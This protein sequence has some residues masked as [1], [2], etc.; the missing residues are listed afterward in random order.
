M[1]LINAMLSL[2]ALA[3][4]IPLAIHLLFR[5]RFRSIQWGAMHLLD[6]VV[7][8][9]HRRLQWLQILLLLLRC[10]L[11]VLLA[12][13]LARPVLTGFRSLPGDAPQSLI[14]AVD[15]SRSMSARDAAGQ[16]S[17][18]RARQMLLR[19]VN[20]LS[21]QD[22]V[23][24]IRS[25]QLGQPAIVAGRTDA[26]RR[27][28]DLSADTG[29]IDLPG[30]VRASL[31]AADEA[32]HSQRR[33]VI[34]SDFQDIDLSDDTIESLQR[35]DD[36]IGDGSDSPSISFL[37]VGSTSPS[38]GNVYFESV[39]LD[40]PA[41]IAGRETRLT[42]QIQNASDVPKQSV[43]VTWSVDSEPFASS[44][45]AMDA[46]SSTTI[47][48]DLAIDQT[49]VH[50]L[51][52]SIE[53]ADAIS[54]DNQRSLGVDV[55]HEV[56]VV[57]VDGAPS[58][59]PMRAETDF[60]IVALSPLSLANVDRTDA[61]RS[62]VIG[63]QKIAATIRDST[64]DVLVLANV[65]EIG[66][67]DRQAVADFVINGGSLV[68]FDGDLV[69]PS[70]Y[71]ERWIGKQGSWLLPATLGQVVGSTTDQNAVSIPIDPA[72]HQ[73]AP[74]R[75]LNSQDR[76]MFDDVELFGYRSLTI[77][78]T[79][80]ATASNSPVVMLSTVGRDPL[81]LS[82]VRGRGQIVQFAIPCDDAWSG[83]PLRPMFVPMIQQLVLDLAGSQKEA[84][85]EIGR[86]ISI[87]ISE[88]HADVD[89]TTKIE[90]AVVFP[91]EKRE[92]VQ[93]DPSSVPPAL[94]VTPTQPGLHR[95][96][97][98]LRPATGPTVVSETS[99]IVEVPVAESI[100]RDADTNRLNAA[101]API[102]AKIFFDESDL[103]ADDHNRRYGR[104]VWRPLLALVLAAMIGEVVL[105]QF[106]AGID[107]LGNRASVPV[108]RQV[109][110]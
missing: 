13:C 82:A 89:D 78:P 6:S 66:Q 37:S 77:N 95:L 81:I 41:V 62:T 2:G 42:A 28:R 107:V 39:A 18:Q 30:V 22:E 35:L 57:L 4:T 23:I 72:N 87:P 52:V 47:H 17:M 50:Q 94:I 44:E 93:T 56:S 91:D 92:T 75:E 26:S 97:A 1:T 15:D 100:L 8:V 101:A 34:V 9:N 46:R 86:S 79:D 54:A 83:L 32:S 38:L 24:L 71:N 43:R 63:Q 67:E 65:P 70:T 48:A 31:A 27:L 96:Y 105:Q 99:R 102:Q 108:N 29:P 85:S 7:R 68:V 88:L 25:S 61:I 45:V 21:R 3:F 14:L 5:T 76:S 110:R 51:G 98:V 73:Y 33:I 58:S 55:I 104:E 90:Y 109:T 36:R 40:S 103:Q 12:F 16:T 74:W 69:D 80:P 84:T 49:G 53:M 20:D 60:L 64:P 10:L 59:Q 19:L 106:R 11:P